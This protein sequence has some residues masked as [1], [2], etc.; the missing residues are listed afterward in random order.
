MNR[1]IVPGDENIT[2]IPVI[3]SASLIQSYGPANL[4]RLYSAYNYSSE[5]VADGG[6][7]R[8]KNISFGYTFE[9]S[10]IEKLGLST[11]RLSM[12]STNPFLIYS[13]SKLG[14]Q[15]MR[16]GSLLA[17]IFLIVVS[18]LHLLRLIFGLDFTVGDVFIPMWASIVAVV[19]PGL[20]A[21]LLWRER[22]DT[23]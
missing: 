5:R 11:F 9:K 17:M 8:M 4:G 16:I 18:F 20:I 13:D 22:G 23:N 10:T 14:G 2:N 12:Q 19:G 7:I 1:W 6:F 3:P 21:F 15:N